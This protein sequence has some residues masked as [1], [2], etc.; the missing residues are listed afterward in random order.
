MIDGLTPFVE[1]WG[2]GAILVVVVLANAGLPVPGESI[3]VVAG[4]L[5]WRGE[6]SLWH[7]LVVGIVSASA[8]NGIGY[9]LG[10]QFGAAAVRRYGDRVLVSSAKLERSRL[11]FL[12]YGA[13]AIAIARFVPGLHY[14]AGPVAGF[15][16]MS[17]PAFVVANV[18]GACCYVPAVVGM[19][20]AVGHGAGLQL[21]RLRP[22]GVAVEHIILGIAII[23]T[24]GVLA[25]RLRRHGPLPRRR[26]KP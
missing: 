11:F 17:A 6:L 2:Y 26:A 12:K 23:G 16:R 15:T 21:E 20:Y 18:L 7:V 13:P 5:V 3:L 10:R 1:H 19:G 4:Y 25:N 8:G 24:L 22:S 14:A 9:W